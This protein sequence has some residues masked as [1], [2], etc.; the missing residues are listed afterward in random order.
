MKPKQN[1]QIHMSW[2]L[3]NLGRL[4]KE[5]SNLDKHPRESNK[6]IELLLLELQERLKMFNEIK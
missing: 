1:K 6:K 4:Q 3:D 5:I 2:M